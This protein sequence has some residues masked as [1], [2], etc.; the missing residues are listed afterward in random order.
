[1]QSRLQ[2]RDRLAGDGLKSNA[3]IQTA[4]VI[5]DVHRWQ[6]SSYIGSV[7]VT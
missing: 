6:A 3:F 2:E 5:V 7:P 1:M 4:R